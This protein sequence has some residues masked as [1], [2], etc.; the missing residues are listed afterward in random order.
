MRRHPEPILR[1]SYGGMLSRREWL[2]RCALGCGVLS[3]PRV[4]GDEPPPAGE[5]LVRVVSREAGQERAREGKILVE[6][7]EGGVVLIEPSGHWHSLPAEDLVSRTLVEGKT[8]RPFTTDELA[9]R[10]LVELG[11][12]F[13][14]ES[15]PPYVIATNTNKPY[16]QWCG[17]LLNRLRTS[18]EKFWAK[19]EL[20]F[21]TPE[22]P[23]PVV[24]FATR[25]QYSEYALKT[26][27]AA[28]AAAYG[29]YSIAWNRMAVFDSL[30][31]QR[32]QPP[33]TPVE[34]NQ[35]MQ[36]SLANVTN[37]VHEATHQYAYN[38]GLHTRFADNPLWLTEGMALF[39]EVPDLRSRD[40]WAT[41]GR[42]N[43]YQAGQ[44]RQ[45]VGGNRPEDSLQTLIRD[46]VR[47]T[48]AETAGAAYA[49]SW[50]LTYHLI[51]RQREE[52]VAYLKHIAAKKVLEF[53]DGDE[54]QAEFEQF[55]GDDWPALDKDVLA[56]ARRAR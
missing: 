54:R 39:F 36:G 24:V 16:A 37:L 42:A 40:G 35:R 15:A 5:P 28:T 46:D 31:E 50:A 56:T 18:F 12:G 21:V 2:R 30:A 32:G 11:A 44:F 1:D 14:V 52:Y 33:R 8:F 4:W 27:D 48:D 10:L 22:F 23:L 49:E 38:A 6:D 25:E 3:V 51:K 26:A 17:A 43:A 41:M 9:E 13:G 53:L 55:F 20:P 19:D 45:Y 7:Q 29:F 47:F 34:V